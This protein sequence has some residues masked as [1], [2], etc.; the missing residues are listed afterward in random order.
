MDDSIKV[1]GLR[2]RAA[3]PLRPAEAITSAFAG[4]PRDW[5]RGGDLTPV[6][7]ATTE[8]C[9]LSRAT[10]RQVGGFS[11]EFVAPELKSTDFMLK[12]RIAGIPSLWLP[13]VELVALDERCDDEGAYWFRNRLVVD[14]WGFGRKW[15]AYLARTGEAA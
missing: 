6:L 12:A 13:T 1:A 11:H 3:P 5:L 15:S 9:V 14:E 7:A 10:L 4:Y 8:C 2:Q